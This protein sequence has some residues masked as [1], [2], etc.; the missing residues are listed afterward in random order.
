VDRRAL[1]EHGFDMKRTDTIIIGG[2]QAGLAMSRSLGDR[3]IDHV[4][5]ERGRI[6]ERWRSERWNSLRLLTPRWQSRLPG[7]SYSGSDPDGYMTKSEV[8]DFLDGYASSFSAPVH[9][10]VAVEA[11]ERAGTGFRIQ[12]NAGMWHAPNVVIA[13]GY[14]DLPHVPSMA[15]SLARDIEQVA[16]TRYSDPSQL[17]AGGVLV[18][19]AS[20]TGIQLASE[21]A[22]SGRPVTLAVGRHI[23]LPRTYRGRDIMAW[24]DRMGM[25]KASTGQV[26]DIDAS[27]TQPS[28]QLIGS[29]DHRSLDLDVLRREG[30]LIVGRMT[31]A[32][33]RDIYLAGDLAATLDHAEIKMNELLDRVDHFIEHAGIAA[34]YPAGERPPRIQAPGTPRMLDL[35]KEGIRTVLWATGYRRAYPWLRVPV[36]DARGELVHDGGITAE[37]GLYA[38][39]LQFMRRRNSSFLDGVGADAVELAAHIQNR[40]TRSRAAVA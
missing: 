20:A 14:C 5:L 38:L 17:P 13:T 2:G 22:R 29:D 28:L 7:W 8:I 12:T 32:S 11:V 24:F 6:A 21:I 4:I 26:W 27:R 1:I 35:A 31:G 34:H 33:G 15:A 25:L 30:V 36:L 19:G 37:P 9:S 39:G 16:P 3:G 10:G 18:V 23:R 40:L